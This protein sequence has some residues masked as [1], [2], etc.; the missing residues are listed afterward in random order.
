MCQWTTWVVGDTVF[1]IREFSQ[2]NFVLGGPVMPVVSVICGNCGY[3]VLLN[4]ILTGFVT[5]TVPEIPTPQAQDSAPQS[6][7]P[8]HHD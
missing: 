5:A 8:P 3:T 7:E 6:P 4:A 2:G 1:E